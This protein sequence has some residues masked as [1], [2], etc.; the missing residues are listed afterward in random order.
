MEHDKKDIASSLLRDNIDPRLNPAIRAFIARNGDD[1]Q[2][3]ELMAAIWDGTRGEQISE[4][5]LGEALAELHLRQDRS[6]HRARRMRLIRRTLR[7]A[8]C[9]ALPLVACLGLWRYMVDY[10]SQCAEMVEV[11]V[12]RGRTRHLVLADGT[13][14]R[15]NSGSV[16]R[17]PRKFNRWKGNREVYILGEGSFQVSR[18]T[19]HPFIVHAS[20]MSVKVLGTVFNLK[21]YPRDETFVTTLSSGLVEASAGGLTRRLRP[22]QSLRYSRDSHSMRIVEADV[23]KDFGWKQGNLNFVDEP[24]SQIAAVI[25]RHFDKEVRIRAGVDP[26][27]RFTMSFRKGEPVATVLDVLMSVSPD[28]S[29]QVKGDTIVIGKR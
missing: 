2:A 11:V 16:F 10:S 3:D 24:L 20:E 21:A 14:V 22:R 8:A 1:E 28:L 6:E 12:P 29:C 19:R 25:G 13:D 27:A 15:L 17:Y 5:E 26:S 4:E 23:E 18:D 9:I 7:L